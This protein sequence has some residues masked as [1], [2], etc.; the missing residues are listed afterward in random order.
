MDRRRE[1]YESKIDGQAE[2]EGRL[3]FEAGWST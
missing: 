1:C 3:A 2:D